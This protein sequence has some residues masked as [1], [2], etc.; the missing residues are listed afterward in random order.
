VCG[1]VLVG[2][3]MVNGG[4]E[5]EGIWLI[6]FMYLYEIEHENAFNCF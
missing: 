4:D 1:K 2:G 6:G 5:S 3:G